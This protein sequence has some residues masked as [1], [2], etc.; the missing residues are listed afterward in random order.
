MLLDKVIGILQEMPAK[1]QKKVLASVDFEKQK[2]SEVYV[3]IIKLM[4]SLNK[5]AKQ[6]AQLE[7]LGDVIPTDEEII[8]TFGTKNEALNPVLSFT[9]EQK[10]YIKS[11]VYRNR[12]GEFR[13]IPHDK[14]VTPDVIPIDGLEADEAILA[15]K[16]SYTMMTENGTEKQFDG[17][18]IL[19]GLEYDGSEDE[20]YKELDCAL[21]RINIINSFT[22]PYGFYREGEQL[23]RNV[24]CQMNDNLPE[25][26]QKDLRRVMLLMYLVSGGTIENWSALYKVVHHIVRNPNS[27]TGII[28]YLNDFD[29]GGNGKSKFVSVLQ[30]MFGDSF[31][32]FSTQQLRFTISLLGKRLVSIAEF[33]G[34]STKKEILSMLKAM[35]GRDLFEYEAKGTKS[36]VAKSYQNFI[37]SSNHYVMFDDSGVKRRLQNFQC[38]NLLHLLTNKY[39]KSYGYLDQFFGDTYTEESARIEERM[40]AALLDYIKKDTKKYEL[41][42]REQPIVLS[43]LKNPI[44]R[45]MFNVNVDYDAF[46]REEGDGSALD[47]WRVLKDE[48]RPEQLNYA[49]SIIQLW[50][51]DVDFEVSRDST[52]MTCSIPRD[53]FVNKLRNR[54]EELDVMSRQLKC[55]TT[56]T[57][58]R[59][60]FAGFDVD[61]L[62]DEFLFNSL[63]KKVPIEKRGNFIIVGEQKSEK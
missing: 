46:I 8:E 54:L 13:L 49:A 44:L 10:E 7:V 56:V 14:H 25:Y 60:E 12:D 15:T 5:N 58:E 38:C 30:N 3:T 63:N 47:L 24:A 34:M 28:L 16:L 31:T 62:L 33:E 23:V 41:P 11:K 35:T 43:S 4:M 9:D 2:P 32:A 17:L 55:K 19:K 6:R 52:V 29:A 53:D 39:T 21:R 51:P 42:I 18:K 37:L 36:I 61:S 45:K 48:V 27:H 22:K 59:G 57:L 26:E 50:L 1:A 40:A 20:I